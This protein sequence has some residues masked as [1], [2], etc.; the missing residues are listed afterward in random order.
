MRLPPDIWE[1]NPESPDLK[2]AR[3]LADSAGWL[4]PWMVLAFNVLLAVGLDAW[5]FFGKA[6]P[7][8]ST[9]Q[10]LSHL[11]EEGTPAVSNLLWGYFVRLGDFLPGVSITAWM[12]GVSMACGVACVAV[13]TLLLLRQGYWVVEKSSPDAVRRESWARRLAALSGG[14]FLAVSA[15][16]WVASTRSFPMTFHMLLLLGW[17]TCHLGYRQT[18]RRLLLSVSLLAWGVLATQTDTGWFLA[19]VALWM[20][21]RE[22]VHWSHHKSWLAWLAFVFSPL[23]GLSLYWIMAVLVYRRGAWLGM[24]PGGRWE[25]LLD[26]LRAQFA[27]LYAMHFSPALLVFVCI[28]GVP[29]LT[30]FVMSHRCP[31]C[32]EG[33]EIAIRVLFGIGLATIAWTPPYSPCFLVPGGLID[34][35]IAPTLLLAACFGCTIGETWLMGDLRPR[36]DNTFWKRTLR[37]AMTTLTLLLIP[38]MAAAAVWNAGLVKIPDGLWTFHA[39]RDLFAQREHHDVMLC[40]APFDDL[41]LMEMREERMPWVVMS[42]SRAHN[43]QYLKLLSIRFP[44]SSETSMYF[45]RD[46]FDAGTRSW[47]DTEEGVERTMTIGRP[48]VYREYGWMAP[49]G[50]A[51]RIELD[52]AATEL[53]DILRSQRPFWENVASQA[54]L[55]LRPLNPYMSFWTVCNAIVARQVNDVGV[56]AADEGRFELADDLFALAERIQASNLSVK[57][58]RLRVGA[59][60]G[61]SEDELAERREAYERETWVSVGARWVLGAYFGYVWDTEGWMRDGVVWALSGAPLNESGARRKSALDRAVDGR[62]ERWFNQAY[63]VAGYEDMPVTLFRQI[64]MNNPWD[65]EPLMELARL[66]LRDKRPD[67]AEAYFREAIERGIRSETLSFEWAMTD[68]VRLRFATRD[69]KEQEAFPAGVPFNELTVASPLHDPGRWILEDGTVRDPVPV[70]RELADT[71]PADMRIWMVLN[72]L[73]DGEE[74]ETDRIEKVLK[75]QR[76]N[77]ADVWLSLCDLHIKR[78]EW[79]KARDELNHALSLDSERVKLWEMAMSIAEHYGNVRLLLSAKNRLLRMQPFH[80][81][82]QQQQGQELYSKGDLEG[83][84]RVFQQGIFFKRDPVLLNNLAHVLTEIDAD[85][86]YSD[87]ILLINEAIKRNPDRLGFYAT[88]ANI[89]LRHGEPR[90]A[91][92]DIRLATGG[93]SPGL[94]ELLLLAEICQAMDDVPHAEAALGKIS[95][96]KAKP[97]FDEQQRMFAVRDWIESRRGKGVAKGGGA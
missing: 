51:S 26:I 71:T 57:M 21:L 16:F 44:P 43:P 74:P 73:A 37:R 28:L 34:P 72:L 2:Q 46:N 87:A 78:E 30:L 95:R 85:A 45:A 54:D 56:R 11:R 86:N 83:A 69:G 77:D 79:K 50:I 64:L 91:L 19:P 63:L 32:Y 84:A 27:N 82:A 38:G 41:A 6:M 80:F 33:A 58:N 76:P 13:L 42:Y 93:K 61:L 67:I 81:L 92:D 12:A 96:L 47:F 9:R 97:R 23:A 20:A 10:I 36:I 60:L 7:G 65:T 25:A 75:T 59:K 1:L 68:F 17:A 14:M 49:V 15:P 39:M 31:W 35:P 62:F 55:V 4:R 8:I 89:H 3:R 24:Y 88:R 40:G 18:G 22:M 94:A 70:F 48:D 53:D 29:W 5:A 52:P 66:A 90:T